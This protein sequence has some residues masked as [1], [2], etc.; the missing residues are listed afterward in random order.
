[1]KPYLKN[2]N[3]KKAELYIYGD[4]V[5]TKFFE[6][7]VTSFEIAEQLSK[8][9][10]E[11]IAVYISS[12]G[13][14]V[15]AGLAIYNALKHHGA[16]VKT[17]CDGFA[18]SIASVI[19]MAGDERIMS[20]ASLMMIHNPWAYAQGNAE[21]LRKTAE[22][23]EKIGEASV[24]AYL[25]RASVSEEEVRKLLDNETWLTPTEALD[26]GF[27]TA[28]IGAE[29]KARYCQSVRKLITQKLLTPA[30]GGP[31]PKGPEENPGPEE[32]EPEQDKDEKVLRMLGA[33]YNAFQKE[34]RK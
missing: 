13:G 9:D 10:A 32:K 15:A 26:Y 1:M 16:R 22:D 6:E 7:D 4:I 28:V 29:P 30:K 17:Y 20:N 18:C 27:A 2:V 25:E 12:Y 14:S 3:E 31:D 11:E 5:D 23:L 21:E 8:T 33:F 34:E 19:F 24:N